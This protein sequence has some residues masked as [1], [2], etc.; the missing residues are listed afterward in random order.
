[1]YNSSIEQVLSI[2]DLFEGNLLSW[3]QQG[4]LERAKQAN[5]ALVCVAVPLHGPSCNPLAEFIRLFSIFRVYLP[6]SFK[7]RGRQRLRKRRLIKKGIRVISN[8]VAISPNHLLRKMQ[9]NSHGVESL[10]G[11][12]R[13]SYPSSE[14][15]RKFRRCL[16]SYYTKREIRHLHVVVVQ[17]RQCKEMQKKSWCTFCLLNLLGQHEKTQMA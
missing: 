2:K 11:S 15:E 4:N 16:F 8:F 9:R 13:Q 1:M 12:T 10:R 7:M 3:E 6:G 14:R 17:R 5:L